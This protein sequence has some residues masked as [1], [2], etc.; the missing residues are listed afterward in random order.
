M[1]EKSKRQIKS[2]KK[3]EF[4]LYFLLLYLAAY[5]LMLP[6]R[7][8]FSNPYLRT[9]YFIS[10]N[11]WNETSN[12]LLFSVRILPNTFHF[13]IWDTFSL[14]VMSGQVTYFS[15]DI[16]HPTRNYSDLGYYVSAITRQQLEQIYGEID[17]VL[18]SP[19]GTKLAI[20]TSQ[21]IDTGFG[22]YTEH[23]LILES[24]N[25][26]ILTELNSNALLHLMALEKLI[27]LDSFL[28]VALQGLLLL[29]L[30]SVLFFY[31]VKRKY[32]YFIVLPLV[33]VLSYLIS[34]HLYYT[35]WMT[36]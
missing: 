35:G 9:A 6:V 7:Y 33:I 34:I 31:R 27:P 8:G 4:L 5:F 29:I 11:A 21:H 14:D 17:E 23:L 10:N 25:Y 20:I 30:S 13:P 16:V 32:L 28:T 2:T 19:D 12:E 26:A 15:A 3:W 24:K 18:V 1:S 22:F 36:S